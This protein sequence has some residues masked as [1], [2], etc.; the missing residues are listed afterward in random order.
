MTPDV[1]FDFISRQIMIKQ[2]VCH[3]S[4]IINQCRERIIPKLI[5]RS[6]K[7]N[8]SSTDKEKTTSKQ[9]ILFYE[10]TDVVHESIFCFYIMT[11]V[12]N[13][14]FLGMLSPNNMLE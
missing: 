6:W 9:I 10:S 8:Q 1:L 11:D 3:K 13:G 7:T 12:M 2:S 4:N 5:K 14:M